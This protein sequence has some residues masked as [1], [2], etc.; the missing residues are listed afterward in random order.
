MAQVYEHSKAE[1][2]FFF[3]LCLHV[4]YMPA[5]APCRE[6]A[7]PV[8]VGPQTL[9]KVLPNSSVMSPVIE[10]DGAGSL[11]LSVL[12]FLTH[13]RKHLAPCILKVQF[14]LVRMFFPR[15]V[16]T[17]FVELLVRLVF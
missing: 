8:K 15:N 5:W 17:L 11:F 16:V 3:F 2:C 13:R 6:A 4:L 10:L 9:Q 1:R 14:F 12:C 7:L